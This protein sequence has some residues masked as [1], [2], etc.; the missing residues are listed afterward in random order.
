MQKNRYQPDIYVLFIM[1]RTGVLKVVLWNYLGKVFIKLWVKQCHLRLHILI[2]HQREHWEHGVDCSVAVNISNAAL[3]QHT[4]AD[5][6][7]EMHTNCTAVQM[8][9][10]ITT[11]TETAKNSQ[12]TTS[13]LTYPTIRKPWYS[14][15]DAK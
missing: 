7:K 4:C 13:E 8:F 3:T 5:R 10:C 9:N 6:Q 1:C 12:E 2:Q 11:S 14:G 15:T